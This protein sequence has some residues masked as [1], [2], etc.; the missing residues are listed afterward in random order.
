M[1][2]PL[3]SWRAAH[4]D[5][6]GWD[7]SLW[8]LHEDARG[9]AGVALCARLDEG[10]GSVEYLAVAERSRRRGVGRALLLHGLAALR[11]AGLTVG[12][13][14]VQAENANAAR[15]YESVGMRTFSTS[16]R[17]DKQLSRDLAPRG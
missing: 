3:E 12:E 9:P 7:P 14:F 17:W 15:L 5:K 16:E 4:I 11:A 13:L 8:L 2:R 10:V 6:A 1:P